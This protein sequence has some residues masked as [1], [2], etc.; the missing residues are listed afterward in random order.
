[1]SWFGGGSP[2]FSADE[3]RSS[4]LSLA[5]GIDFPAAAEGFVE[6]DK[7]GGDRLVGLDERVLGRE[8]F[9]LGVEHGE[10][11]DDA[12]LVLLSRQLDGSPCGGHGVGKSGAA[13]LLAGV[14]D[15]GVLDLLQGLQN[16]VAIG[17][18]RLATLFG[19]GSD[20]ARMRPA[21]NRFHDTPGLSR[22]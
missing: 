3:D 11:V 10:K 5:S 13:G 4:L 12:S 1:M 17:E 6:G 20:V 9:T 21:S 7:V 8:K 2:S 16:R 22:K 18:G 14:A 19:T 15:Q